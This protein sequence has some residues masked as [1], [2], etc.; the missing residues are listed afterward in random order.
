MNQ[1]EDSIRWPDEFAPNRAPIHVRNELAISAPASIV[2]AWL[3]R[4][5]DWP[6]WYS[7]SHDVVLEN[8]AADLAPGVTF[9]WRTFGVRLLSHVEEF[10]PPERL[11]WNAR[12]LGVWVYHAWIV[13]PSATGCTVLTEET[14]YGFLARLG[15]LLM[16]NRMYRL[17]QLW[18]EALRDNAQGGLPKT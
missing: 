6:S 14:Q 2:W 8:E 16:P 12:G 15:H 11:A 3:I 1:P 7:N 9:R 13:R 17:H 4:A 5:R 18:L 10:V